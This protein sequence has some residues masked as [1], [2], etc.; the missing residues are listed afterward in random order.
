MGHRLTITTVGMVLLPTIP[1]CTEHFQAPDPWLAD[2][3]GLV[4]QVVIEPDTA[5][6]MFI[7]DA[8][9]LTATALNPAGYP[10]PG[11]AALWDTDDTTVAL[12]S[13][14]GVLR[15]AGPG[16]ATVTATIG[17]VTGRATLTVDPGLVVRNAC[18]RCHWTRRPGGHFAWGFEWTACLAC[19]ETTEAGHEDARNDHQMAA[20]FALSGAHAA[21][22]CGS[23][24]IAGTGSPTV[25]PAGPA[26]CAPCHRAD[27][28]VTH[29]ARGYPTACLMCHS[30]ESW[31]REAFDH[32]ALAEGYALSAVH[33]TLSCLACHAADTFQPLW[34]PAGPGDC[35]ACHADDY[36]ARHAAD[37][38]PTR[39][40]LCHGEAAWSGATFDHATASG[41]YALTGPHQSLACTACHDPAT[42]APKWTP[43]SR[44]DCDACHGS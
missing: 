44:T 21:A 25:I 14:D 40:L 32:A 6:L 15:A 26:D 41:G 4:V 3:A 42:W 34:S 12:V 11:R 18:T 22:A 16:T 20:G 33:Q 13:S 7:D 35:Y 30:M 19:H 1:A 37:G 23:C 8:V 28:E 27:Y 10:L 9:M 36:A 31:A 39:C 17:D 24:H 43:A 29:G 2:S 38:Y 5:R